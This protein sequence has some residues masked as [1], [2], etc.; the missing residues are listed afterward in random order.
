MIA[1]YLMLRVVLKN[2][3]KLIEYQKA[4]F[5]TQIEKNLKI[6]DVPIYL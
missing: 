1:W 2:I 5:T 4:I 3:S 6:Q